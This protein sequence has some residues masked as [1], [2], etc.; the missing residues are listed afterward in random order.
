MPM[1]NPTFSTN[2]LSFFLF[3]LCFHFS[4]SVVLFL[5]SR[6]CFCAADGLALMV[7]ID[8]INNIEWPK[9]KKTLTQSDE[10]SAKRN[11]QVDRGKCDLS[12]E[13]KA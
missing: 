1:K 3:S 2:G 8:L 10:I 6:L 11:Y 4:V 9:H 12:V 5:N 13:K 7:G